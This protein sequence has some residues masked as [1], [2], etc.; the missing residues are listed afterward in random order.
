[1]DFSGTDYDNEIYILVEEKSCRIPPW[2]AFISLISDI[3][4]TTRVAC[5]P[6]IAAPAHEFKTVLKQAQG[7]NCLI[8]GPD[9]NFYGARFVFT[10]QATTN[11]TW[12][13]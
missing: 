6:L 3:N 12:K 5:L 13:M 9:S 8:T 4:I 1:M 10:G 7:M 11:V 2:S